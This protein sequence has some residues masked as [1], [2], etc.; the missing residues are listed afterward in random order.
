MIQVDREIKSALV[1]FVF[2]EILV[3]RSCQML[4]VKMGELGQKIES[5]IC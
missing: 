3:I 4:T 2:I 5:K 1:T